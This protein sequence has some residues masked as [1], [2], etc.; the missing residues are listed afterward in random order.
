M[1]EIS[2]LD[3]FLE[4]GCKVLPS[5][6]PLYKKG[7]QYDECCVFC[8]NIHNESHSVKEGNIPI[9]GLYACWLC[10]SEIGSYLA[11]KK[12]AHNFEDKK[13]LVVNFALFSQDV[14][15]YY[16]HLSY[17]EDKYTEGKNTKCYLCNNTFSQNKN[18]PPYRYVNVPV[19]NNILGGWVNICNNCAAHY[20]SGIEDTYKRLVKRKELFLC[21]CPS[22]SSKYHITA[23]ENTRRED[24]QDQKFGVEVEWLCPE[25]FYYRNTR[26]TGSEIYYLYENEPPRSTQLLRY[27]S[28]MCMNCLTLFRIDLML[29]SSSLVIRH[30]TKYG[31][32]CLDCLAKGVKHFVQMPNVVRIDNL[33][34]K[35]LKTTE[36]GKYRINIYKANY[37]LPRL[38]REIDQIPAESSADALLSIYPDLKLLYDST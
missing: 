37:Q 8:G 15:K 9:E 20:E 4:G 35:V 3:K 32:I 18:Q 11:N 22:C 1:R 33:Y 26:A 31:L 10:G 24:Y 5:D 29:D 23:E 25:C 30:E 13:N 36:E 6:Y 16:R 19:G 34:A 14:Y 27:R 12:D 17:V 38:V 28:H 21:S 2:Y 7:G